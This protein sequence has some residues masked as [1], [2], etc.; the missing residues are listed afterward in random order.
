MPLQW[1][2]VG[3]HEELELF[4]ATMGDPRAHGFVIHGAPGVGKTRL[5]DQCLALADGSGRFVARAT[6]TEGSRPIPL[7]ALAHLL[8]PGIGDERCDLVTVMSEVRPVLVAQAKNGPLVL[9]VDDL[10]LL[11]TTSA[12]F[13]C[14]LVD[15]DLVFLVSTVRSEATLPPGL[16]ALWHR[17]RVR[18]VDLEDLD[19]AAV[20]TL[21]HLVLRGPVEVTTVTDIWTASRGNVLFVRELVLGAVDAGHLVDQHGVWR[22]TGPLVTT[23]RLPGARRD[24]PPLRCRRRPPMRSIGWPCGSRRVCRRW[25]TC[26]GRDQLELL[27]RAGLLTVRA[28]WSAP[29]RDACPSAARR[30]PPRP[31]AGARPSSSPPRAR[32]PPRR[33]RR[34]SAR[35]PAPGGDCPPRGVG[36]GRART[37]SCGSARLARYGQDF[38]TGRAARPGRASTMA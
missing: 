10:H 38:A 2:L 20:D 18:R 25:R 15:A 23:P 28:G 36:L 8:P 6:A 5:A 22:L 9:F 31:H 21:L 19:R 35:G 17:A 3:R 7:G 27:D 11:D 4:S 34:S 12:T 37:C 33:P 13:V 30:D 14:Q 24:P 16:D 32:R 1:P 26:V 29:D